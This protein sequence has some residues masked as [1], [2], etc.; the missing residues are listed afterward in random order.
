MPNELKF[1]NTQI[2]PVVRI[3]YNDGEYF[4]PGETNL[5]LGLKTTIPMI[6]KI[7]SV[8]KSIHPTSKKFKASSLKIDFMNYN[9]GFKAG[10]PGISLSFKFSDIVEENSLYGK[11]IELRY[12]TSGITEF[13]DCFHV[14]T[15]IIREIKQINDKRFS[16]TAEDKQSNKVYPQIPRQY[17]DNNQLIPMQYGELPTAKGVRDTKNIIYFDTEPIGGKIDQTLQDIPVPFLKIGSKDSIMNIQEE[18]SHKLIT[19]D[20]SDYFIDEP[21]IGEKQWEYDETT[22]TAKLLN[23]NLFKMDIIQVLHFSQNTNLSLTTSSPSNYSW[24]TP[25]Q[26]QHL[27]DM[28]LDSSLPQFTVTSSADSIAFESWD[29][30]E[31][32]TFSLPAEIGATTTAKGIIN[33]FINNKKIF[34]STDL[35]TTSESITVTPAHTRRIDYNPPT[36]VNGIDL[37]SLVAFLGSPWYTDQ[38]DELAG[39]YLGYEL[40]ESYTYTDGADIII[41][42]DCGR[43][44]SDSDPDSG[45]DAMPVL[46]FSV[47]ENQVSIGAAVIF[48][49]ETAVTD[50]WWAGETVFNQMKE[51]SLLRIAD[52]TNPLN[53]NFYGNINGRKSEDGQAIINPIEIIANIAEKELGIAV[54]ETEKQDALDQ[55]LGWI[56][57]ISI[58]K[59]TD[60]IKIIEEIAEFTLTWPYITDTGSLGFITPKHQY[61]LQDW[62]DAEEIKIKDIKSYKINRTDLQKVYTQVELFYQK[63]P[64]GR[65]RS[66]TGIAE[67]Q[68]GGGLDET[69]GIIDGPNLKEINCPY[70]YDHQTATNIRDYI[71]RQHRHPHILLKLK[72]GPQYLDLELGDIVKITELI[73]GIKAYGIDYTKLNLLGSGHQYAYPIFIISEI[74]KSETGVR[75]TLYQLHHIAGTATHPSW[76]DLPTNTGEPGEIIVA[77]EAIL[78]PVITL[79]QQ[80]QTI[81]MDSPIYYFTVPQATAYDAVDGDITDQIEVSRSGYATEMG[82][83]ISFFEGVFE[84]EYRVTDSSGIEA[85]EIFTLVLTQT[86]TNPVITKIPVSGLFEFSPVSGTIYIHKIPQGGTTQAGLAGD[87]YYENYVTQGVPEISITAWD[88]EDG[89]LTDQIWYGPEIAQSQFFSENAGPTTPVNMDQLGTHSAGCYVEDSIGGFDYQSWY[90]Q[91]IPQE[92]YDELIAEIQQSSGDVNGDGSVDVLDIVTTVHYVLGNL[93]F[94]EEQINQADMNGDGTVDVLDIV[95]MVNK[96]MNEA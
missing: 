24:L 63:L 1:Q 88:L 40:D 54:E 68:G 50:G 38:L 71:F 91:V 93:E 9:T 58:E 6:E 75:V 77:D 42:V 31:M 26:Q 49:A 92:Q 21:L 69:Y 5:Q 45:F 46:G 22:Q 48:S 41:D 66:S 3:D 25:E 87:D 89:I 74:I 53:Q 39:E 35:I 32:W 47:N 76:N 8:K 18:I 62:T 20:E 94:T 95:T 7:S 79:S 90:V 12:R 30:L 33:L 56:F 67:T 2:T 29:I 80:Q 44:V 85:V 36:D 17:T 4:V 83:V 14:F 27:T 64:N 19:N 10:L 43:N 65:Y 34:N 78:P 60:A 70:V 11:E 15:G 57:A 52:I 13:T 61:V 73:D 59:R 16:I 81:V 55:H 84:F 96:V 37:S 86:N 51:I 23:S 28:E 82:A 72:L